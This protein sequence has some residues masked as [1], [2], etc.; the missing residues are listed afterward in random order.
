MLAD[1]HDKIHVSLTMCAHKKS[2]NKKFWPC[3][4]VYDTYFK[5]CRYA[6]YHCCHDSFIPDISVYPKATINTTSIIVLRSAESREKD[7]E[8]ER[9]HVCFLWSVSLLWINQAHIS[10][11]IILIS[12]LDKLQKK[13]GRLC[14][15]GWQN[16]GSCQSFTNTSICLTWQRCDRYRI[17][18][19]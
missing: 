12:W 13:N 8:N 2:V 15:G 9:R 4:Q 1:K 6:Q 5:R 3:I 14:L 7:R 16:L 18:K 11:E 17:I 19:T 10:T